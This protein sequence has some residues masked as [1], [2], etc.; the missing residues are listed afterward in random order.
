MADF[1]ES[2]QHFCFSY[3]F[4]VTT[5]IQQQSKQNRFQNNTI[6]DKPL[7][8]SVDNKFFW[9][10]FVTSDLQQNN[11]DKWILPICDACK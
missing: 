6:V 10:Q 9:N 7:W 11:L 5:S 8:K 3:D 4:D 2:N 1:F